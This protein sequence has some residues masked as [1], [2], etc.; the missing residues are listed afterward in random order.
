MVL[1]ERKIKLK[2]KMTNFEERGK[3]PIW[4]PA[5]TPASLQGELTEMSLLANINS[6]LYKKIGRVRR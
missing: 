5:P 1:L 6:F 2:R 4:S 3:R